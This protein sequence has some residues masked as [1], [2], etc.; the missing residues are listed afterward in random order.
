MKLDANIF[1]QNSVDLVPVLRLTS[2]ESGYTPYTSWM[3]RADVDFFIKSL[4]PAAREQF[5]LRE[6]CTL[7]VSVSA[8]WN[9]FLLDI[10][11]TGG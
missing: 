9:Y 11:I 6:T 4:N 8:L 7:R 1:L 2:S 10:Q 5:L 3:L